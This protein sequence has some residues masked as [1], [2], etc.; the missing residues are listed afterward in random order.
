MKE[1]CEQNIT[2]KPGPSVFHRL[3]IVFREWR[4]PRGGAEGEKGRYLH[5][6]LLCGPQLTVEDGVVYW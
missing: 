3:P 6:K 1:I 5:G 2:E 4:G